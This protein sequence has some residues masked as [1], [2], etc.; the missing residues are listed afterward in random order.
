MTLSR[1]EKMA[2]FTDVKVGDIVFHNGHVARI[3]EKTNITMENPY[4]LIRIVG[5]TIDSRLHST[6]VQLMTSIELPQLKIGDK[7]RVDDIPAYERP[8][9]DGVW[10]SHMINFIGK[11][12]TVKNLWDHPQFGPVAELDGFWFRTYHLSEIPQYDMI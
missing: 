1:K 3:I 10:L 2:K 9:S 8:Q 4:P 5:P 11:E 7:V 6:N 12:Y